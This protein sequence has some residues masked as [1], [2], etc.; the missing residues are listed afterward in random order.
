MHWLGSTQ[1]RSFADRCEL[2]SQMY[3]RV[4]P[5]QEGAEK[6]QEAAPADQEKAAEE[7]NKEKGKEEDQASQEKQKEQKKEEV[8]APLDCL[9]V[10]ER[11][12]QLTVTVPTILG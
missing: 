6:D 11:G 8:K 4:P 1:E 10:L 3:L 12:H 9:F 5:P 7:E 2:L